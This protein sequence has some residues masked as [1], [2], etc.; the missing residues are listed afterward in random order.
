METMVFLKLI[1]RSKKDRFFT[2]MAKKKFILQ[3]SV[4]C[5]IL[6]PYPTAWCYNSIPM[7]RLPEFLLTLKK[8]NQKPQT[9]FFPWVH[10]VAEAFFW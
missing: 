8:T 7:N 3:K 4:L 10:T 1:N 5:Q 2:R 6:S 9:S